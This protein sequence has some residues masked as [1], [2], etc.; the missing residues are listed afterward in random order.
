MA[1]LLFISVCKSWIKDNLEEWKKKIDSTKTMICVS[2]IIG[3]PS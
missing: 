1:V 3:Q 2:K